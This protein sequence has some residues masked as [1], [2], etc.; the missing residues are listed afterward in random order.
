MKKNSK[1]NRVM[2]LVLALVMVVSLIPAGV[3]AA[4]NDLHAGDTGIKTDTLGDEGFI[5]WPVKIYDYP[6]SV[7]QQQ[8]WLLGT[9]P[10][11]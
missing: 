6:W 4:T 7:F 2:A 10:Q 3:F 9:G 5:N 8:V 1:S 11:R